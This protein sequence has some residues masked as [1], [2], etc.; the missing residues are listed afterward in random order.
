[1]LAYAPQTTPSG[2][3]EPRFPR[4]TPWLLWLPDDR[5]MPAALTTEAS[6]RRSRE[7]ARRED[8]SDRAR[9]SRRTLHMSR[10]PSC[11][12]EAP[13][14]RAIIRGCAVSA[15]AT[16]TAPAADRSIVDFPQFSSCTEIAQTRT[17]PAGSA[18]RCPAGGGRAAGSQ[19]VRHLYWLR[20]VDRAH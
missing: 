18:A 17:L 20:R 9:R 10:L 16:R 13:T 11:A 12:P 19:S 5:Q 7:L 3:A 1:M 2:Q 4:G 6:P 14:A 15:V 8:K